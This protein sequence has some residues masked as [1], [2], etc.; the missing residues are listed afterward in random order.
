MV[1]HVTAECDDYFNALACINIYNAYMCDQCVYM[2]WM[3][4]D[5]CAG[6]ETNEFKSEKEGFRDCNVIIRIIRD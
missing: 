4:H 3:M 5:N 6:G 1:P 2:Q